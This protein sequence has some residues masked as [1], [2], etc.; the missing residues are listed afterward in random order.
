[1]K[2]NKTFKK[3]NCAP[4]KT[5]RQQSSSCFDTSALKIIKKHYNEDE[6]NQNKIYTHVRFKTK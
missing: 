5:R 4:N 6:H 3:M 1:M 2:T